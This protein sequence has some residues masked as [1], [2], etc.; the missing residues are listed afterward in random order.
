MFPLRLS[1]N[2]AP[3]AKVPTPSAY[4][5]DPLDPCVPPS[6]YLYDPRRDDVPL[7]QQG[8]VFTALPSATYVPG[9]L[10][11]WSYVPVVAEAVVQAPAQACQAF[12]SEATLKANGLLPRPD[13][14]YLAYAIVDVAAPVYRVGQTAA[15]SNGFGVQKLGW[16]DHYIVAYLDGGEVPTAPEAKDA[17][18]TQMVT[19]KLYY[20]SSI[21][22]SGTMPMPV[23]GAPGAGYDVLEHAR[24]EAGYSPVC[25]VYTYDTGAPLTVDKLPTDVDTINQLYGATIKPAPVPYVF[26]LQVL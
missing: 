26:C 3:Y 1:D 4:V 15:T 21:L 20:P 10:P 19:Q 25:A 24:G 11:T 17:T 2:G 7:D 23:K 9:V 13:G 22:P 18:K 5:F 12:K 8:P 6:N 16:Y 14:K